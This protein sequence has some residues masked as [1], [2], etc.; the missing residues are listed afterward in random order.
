MYLNLR[1]KYKMV[2]LTSLVLLAFSLGGISILQYAFHIYNKE[3]Y[4]QSAQSLQVSSNSVEAELKKMEQLSFQF[5]TD[6]YVQSYLLK[7]NETNANYDKFNL[8]NQLRLRLVDIGSV[9]KYVD[10]VH[11]FDLYDN[12]Y[13]SGKAI[14][15]LTNQRLAEM[16]ELA[17]EEDGRPT[18]LPPVES[19]QTVLTTR[20]IRNYLD[21]SFER[22]G[23]V[24][25]RVDIQEIVQ[26]L[27]QNLE[28]ENT[29]FL[30]FDKNEEMI[31]SNNADVENIMPSRY[32][33]NQDGYKIVKYKNERYFLTY[34][35]A[36]YLGWKYMILIPYNN[37]FTAISNAKTAVFITY[38]CLFIIVLI[39]GLKF[40]GTITNPIE[41]LNKKMKIVQTGN[42]ENYDFDSSTMHL[43]DEAGEMHQ[44]FEE[45]MKRINHLIAENYK[46]QLLIQ[47]AEF[48]TLQAQVNPHF[49]YNTLESINWTAKIKGE[50][51]ISQMAEALAFILRAS[52]NN[53]DK[54]IPLKEELEIVDNLI[55]IQSYRFEERLHFEKNIPAHY[56]QLL[57]PKSIIQPLVENSI[58]YGLEEIM[59]V[60]KIKITV[61]EKDND[62]YISVEDNGAG[63]DPDY[64]MK[65]KQGVH[66]PKGTGIGLNNINER[67]KI[68]FGDEYGIKIESEKEKGTIVTVKVPCGEEKDDVQSVVSR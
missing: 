54:F 7:L 60:C 58:R 32:Q 15:T 57:I 24:G 34:S 8:G 40:T 52:I 51:K 47:E 30:I 44:N 21:F 38:L 22:M 26:N 31:F 13:A 28:E 67:V 9:S 45:M 56:L 4:R 12:E 5:A 2:V 18:W 25:I 27:T 63:M 23:T 1:L 11:I 36:N 66:E 68:L 61:T 48:Q 33:L 65:V 35:D 29:N 46:K 55:T 17:N 16:K 6:S 3:I 41:S 43:K 37:L 59:G 53:A 14:M 49:L 19:D 10:S 20:E 64:L 62:L 39:L 50:T 42:I